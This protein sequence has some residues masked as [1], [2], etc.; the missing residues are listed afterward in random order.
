MTSL[1][2]QTRGRV[3]QIARGTG[4]NKITLSTSPLSTPS[5]PHI[6]NGGDIHDRILACGPSVLSLNLYAVLPQYSSLTD[7]S[8][9]QSC[10]CCL[11]YCCSPLLRLFQILERERERDHRGDEAAQLGWMDRCIDKDCKR[12]STGAECPITSPS[13]FRVSSQWSLSPLT[14]FVLVH[15]IKKIDRQ[16]EMS[17]PVAMV[18]SPEMRARLFIS[19]QCARSSRSARGQAIPSRCERSARG[20]D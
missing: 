16:L 20:N 15:C 10:G 12:Y 18:T 5:A 8:L 2:S 13:L 19:G 14:S 6:S 1:S 11:L 9:P 17:S 3:R 4:G 7:P